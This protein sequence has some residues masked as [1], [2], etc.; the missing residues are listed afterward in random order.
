M[1]A[2][3]RLWLS[4]DD[5]RDSNL[6]V[7]VLMDQRRH[8]VARVPTAGWWGRQQTTELWPFV[9]DREGRLDF[10]SMACQPTPPSER[11]AR[12]DIDDRI[13][14]AGELFTFEYQGD[15][16]QLR[17]RRITDLSQI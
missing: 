6:T 1:N 15:Q 11:Y 14:A 17:L 5:D 4:C 2:F 9:L 12:I 16:W 7:D 8:R 3:R 13:I 10:G